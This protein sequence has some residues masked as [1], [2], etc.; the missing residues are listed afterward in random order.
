MIRER[1]RETLD[2]VLPREVQSR[3]QKAINEQVPDISNKIVQ[4][5]ESAAQRVVPKVARERLPQIIER[6]FSTLAVTNLP[7]VVRDL[8]SK[9]LNEE[10][11][12]RLD[13]VVEQTSRNIKKKVTVTG[14]LLIIAVLIFTAI[15]VYVSVVPDNMLAKLLSPGPKVENSSPGP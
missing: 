6:Q 13:P 8:A 5:V 9:E 2:N 10:L 11:P 1:I 14:L 7:K 15:N 3:V 4:I 12:K